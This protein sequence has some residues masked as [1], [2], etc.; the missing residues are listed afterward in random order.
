MNKDEANKLFKFMEKKLD[1]AV[2]RGGAVILS[3]DEV[4]AILI[5]LGEK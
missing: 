3:W 2:K 5:F 1:A 4:K